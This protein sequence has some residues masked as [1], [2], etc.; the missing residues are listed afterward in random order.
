MKTKGLLGFIFQF[1]FLMLVIFII[2][3]LCT[4]SEMNSDL[5]WQALFISLVTTVGTTLSMK[6]LTFK[7]K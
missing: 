2:Y 1:V 7:N 5:F 3:P 4:N 6:L